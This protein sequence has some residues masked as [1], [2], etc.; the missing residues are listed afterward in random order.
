[1]NSSDSNSVEEDHEKI[2]KHLLKKINSD[3]GEDESALPNGH[4]E[5]STRH[6][7]M[8]LTKSK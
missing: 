2:M 5:P 8:K 1:M 7:N 4:E 6:R 3:D